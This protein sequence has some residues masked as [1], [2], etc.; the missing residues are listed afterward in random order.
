MKRKLFSFLLAGCMMLSLTGCGEE[1]A[2]DVAETILKTEGDPFVIGETYQ[3]DTAAVT[4]DAVYLADCVMAPLTQNEDGSFNAYY[5]Q[6]EEHPD[7]DDAYLYMDCISTI[8][9]LSDEPLDIEEDIYFYCVEND[10]L[11][12]EY[13]LFAENA[14]GSQLIDTKPL[15]SGESARIHY[16]VVLPKDVSWTGL[17][18]YFM[19]TDGTSFTQALN[20]L[21]PSAPTLGIGSTL[22]SKSGI[23]LTLKSVSSGNEIP[24]LTPAGGDTV[25]E[26]SEE[27]HILVDIVIEAVNNSKEP[28]AIGTLYG[29]LLISDSVGSLGSVLLEQ[30]NDMLVSGMIAPGASVTSHLAFELERAPSDSDFFSLCFDGSYY[31]IEVK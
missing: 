31:P 28:T 18:A 8:K 5:A 10:T 20:K 23:D 27:G 15:E 25:I 2:E 9:N 29:G 1:I 21:A 3:D 6:D 13:M 14:D 24:S 19:L 16:A 30:D 11:Y 26:A 7:S 17:N 12:D 22:T 4:V